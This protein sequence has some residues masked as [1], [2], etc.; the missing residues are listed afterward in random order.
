MVDYISF[1]ALNP[2]NYTFLYLYNPLAMPSSEIG[3]YFVWF[4]ISLQKYCFYFFLQSIFAE[5]YFKC[6]FASSAHPCPQ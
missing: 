1:G 5:I 2:I 4:I 3:H 6:K